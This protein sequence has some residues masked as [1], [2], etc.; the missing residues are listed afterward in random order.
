YA[1]I[2]FLNNIGKEPRLD[3]KSQPAAFAA[4]HNSLSGFVTAAAKKHLGHFTFHFEINS[5]EFSISISK[6]IIAG[7][8]PSG[9]VKDDST[10]IKSIP[11]LEATRS[12]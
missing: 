12:K 8:T 10:V 1:S 2:F 3:T 5:M 4:I 6:T 9:S 11:V 7:F